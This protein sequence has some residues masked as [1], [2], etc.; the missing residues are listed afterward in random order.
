MAVEG[1]VSEPFGPTVDAWYANPSPGK[2]RRL[3]ALCQELEITLPPAGDIR[4]QLLHR[5]AS[6]IIEAKRFKAAQAVMIVHSF[7]Q[8]HDWFADYVE[9]VGLYGQEP[10]P[11]ELVST[12]LESGLAL[13]LGWVT[14]PAKYLAV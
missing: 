8:S 2:Q 13:H 10:K 9:F 5:M 3:A 11:G 12:G 7:S 6:A 1:K 14:G 4:Y